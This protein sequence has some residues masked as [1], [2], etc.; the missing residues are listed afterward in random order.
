MGEV[1]DTGRTEI[2]LSRIAEQGI[3]EVIFGRFSYFFE[4]SLNAYISVFLTIGIFG[5]LLFLAIMFSFIKKCNKFS[6]TK[7]NLVAFA[8]L[9]VIIFHSSTESANLVSGS[10]YAA[11]FYSIYV[12]AID[13]HDLKKGDFYGKESADTKT[14]S[15]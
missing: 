4:N 11:S 14:H 3:D 5:L 9:L 15:A 2:F 8:A 13:G 10:F 7:W 12:I 1:L 6:K